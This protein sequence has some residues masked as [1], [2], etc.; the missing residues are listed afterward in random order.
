MTWAEHAADAAGI[1]VVWMRVMVDIEVSGVVT[2]RFVSK[3][4]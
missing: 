1:Q 3:I 4:V 2:G